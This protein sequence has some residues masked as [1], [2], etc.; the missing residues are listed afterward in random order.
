MQKS[1]HK[2]YTHRTQLK[3]NIRPLSESKLE[4]GATSNIRPLS[5][6][7]IEQG[8]TSNIRPLYESKIK[9]VSPDHLSVAH[10]V[11]EASLPQEVAREGVAQ[12]PAHAGSF[13]DLSGADLAHDEHVDFHLEPDLVDFYVEVAVKCDVPEGSSPQAPGGFSPQVPQGRLDDVIVV[14]AVPT[15]CFTHPGLMRVEVLESGIVRVHRHL[16]RLYRPGQPNQHGHHEHHGNL[17][18]QS[19]HS[20][21]RHRQ[22]TQAL[23]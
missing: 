10:E 16:Q 22:S 13:P 9:H 11:R 15:S 4:H 23:A 21:Y 8:A 14:E 6:S 17:P 3:S 18:P 20:A 19:R 12:W 5:E 2:H 7:K 1:P